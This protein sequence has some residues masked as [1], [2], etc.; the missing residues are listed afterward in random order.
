MRIGQIDL[1]SA[2]TG[3]ARGADQNALGSCKA[4]YSK[5]VVGHGRQIK[6]GQRLNGLSGE[7]SLNGDERGVV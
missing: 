4:S 5:G 7:R 1:K 2:R 3:V 6:V